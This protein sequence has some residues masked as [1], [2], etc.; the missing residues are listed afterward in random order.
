MRDDQ[1]VD[2]HAQRVTQPLRD[3]WADFQAGRSTL[4]DLSRTAEQAAAALD[5][6]NA[7]LLGVLES[8]WGDLEYAYYTHEREEHLAVGT[9]MMRPILDAMDEE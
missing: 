8:A 7:D 3:T 6:T 1:R 4:L 9:W 2:E 5:H